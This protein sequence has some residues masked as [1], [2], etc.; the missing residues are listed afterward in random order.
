[1][2]DKTPEAGLPR[3]MIRTSDLRPTVAREV[4]LVA[5]AAQCAAVAAHLGI[6]AVRKLRLVGRIEAEGRSDW[7]LDATLGA[8]VVQDCVVT[9]APV[10]TR[11][12]EPVLRRYLAEMPADPPGEVEM[13]QD[14][15]AEA[16]PVT[17][18]LGAVMIEA[19]SLAL[20][21]YPRADGAALGDA[22]VTAPG[23]RPLTDA[24]LKPFADLGAL[25]DKLAG[26][27]GDDAASDGEE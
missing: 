6:V 3:L 23:V 13:P 14:D 17:L 11:I 8:T 26:G 7:R 21:P 18:D 20:P 24:D 4:S 16:L 22:T 5:N 2:T 9:L 25:R 12:D 27:S 19:L 10:T 15:T 1:M